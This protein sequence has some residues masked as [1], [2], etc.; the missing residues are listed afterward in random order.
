M[1]TSAE[2]YSHGDRLRASGKLSI[3]QRRSM[4]QRIVAAQEA[5][6]KAEDVRDALMAELYDQ[7]LSYGTIGVAL[8]L[9]ST[10]IRERISAYR[11]R[12]GQDQE[13]SS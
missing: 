7:G 12:N 4:T 9:H 11:G 5:V 6:E 8:G 2:R 3:R 10:T 1:S 13:G